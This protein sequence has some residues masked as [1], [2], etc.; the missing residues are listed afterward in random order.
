MP[1]FRDVLDTPDPQNPAAK[2]TAPIAG[3]APS[4]ALTALGTRRAE[5]LFEKVDL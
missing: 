5:K 2:L 1:F 4:A 3:A